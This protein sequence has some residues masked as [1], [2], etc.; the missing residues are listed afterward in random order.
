MITRIRNVPKVSAPRYQVALNSSTRL[1]A[2]M[3]NKCRNTFCCTNSAR[4]RLLSPLPLRKIDRQIRFSR[5]WL[6]RLSTPFAMPT[7]S[8]VA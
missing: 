8:P 4:R 2:L 3:E 5:T 6:T 7:P 1:R